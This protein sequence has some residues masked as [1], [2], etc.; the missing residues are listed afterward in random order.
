M[1]RRSIAVLAVLAPSVLHAAGTV[2]GITASPSPASVGSEVSVVVT[3]TGPCQVYVDFGDK[4]KAGH[5]SQYPGTLKHAYTAAGK[6]VL[7]TFAY[8]SGSEA[9]GLSRC[10]GFADMELVVN[11]KP[12][13]RALAPNRNLHPSASAPSG[14]SKVTNPA[15]SG[16]GA[17]PES[18]ADRSPSPTPTKAA[19]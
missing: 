17:A 8:T 3:A 4:T 16:G 12:P 19:K 18:V 6:Y 9:P 14:V 11:P 1:R 13:T 7:R 2:T 15:P 10:S 5:L